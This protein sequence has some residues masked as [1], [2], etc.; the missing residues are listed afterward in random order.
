MSGFGAASGRCMR[1]RDC[2]LS[3]RFFDGGQ[4][5]RFVLFGLAR[6]DKSDKVEAA[7]CGCRAMGGSQ[8]PIPD[9]GWIFADFSEFGGVASWCWG[10]DRARFS[11]VLR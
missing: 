4:R 8:A 2:R 1:R 7:G 10:C 11:V 9:I 6:V 3:L 5:V